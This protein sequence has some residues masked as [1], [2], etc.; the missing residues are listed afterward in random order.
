VAARPWDSVC[1]ARAVG[2]ILRPRHGVRPLLQRRTHGAAGM[3]DA[4]GEIK[5][6]IVAS[7]Q[8]FK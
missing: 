2:H 4:C 7:I 3:R 1:V 8:A 6:G 5:L